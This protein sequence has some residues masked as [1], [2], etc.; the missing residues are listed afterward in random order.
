MENCATRL[1]SGM[2]QELLDMVREARVY[3]SDDE[4]EELDE[5]M[6]EEGPSV[7]APD[8]SVCDGDVEMADGNK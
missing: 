3:Q 6:I 8:D 7:N 5:E 1:D 4:C 2:R